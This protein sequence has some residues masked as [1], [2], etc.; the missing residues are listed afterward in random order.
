V[1]EEAL[2]KPLK[3]LMKT[4]NCGDCPVCDWGAGI[5]VRCGG[6]EGQLQPS[7]PGRELT[8]EEHDAY[9]YNGIVTK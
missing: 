9:Y 1:L 5:C 2:T 8:A 6:A 3:H 7:C 4:C